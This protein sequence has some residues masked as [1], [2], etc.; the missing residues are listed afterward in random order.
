MAGA[1]EW[2]WP[3]DEAHGPDGNATGSQV[4]WT[5]ASLQAFMLMRA[6]ECL[7]HDPGASIIS[8]SQLDNSNYCQDEHE[9]AIIAE[10]MSINTTIT[11]LRM[12]DNHVADRVRAAAALALPRSRARA[13]A[14]GLTRALASHP[15]LARARMV[16]PHDDIR[17]RSSSPR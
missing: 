4:C 17:A 14:P 3:R 8:I 7:R 2:F 15:P 6:K 11:K 10:A 13:R 12:A 16:H 1:G 9:A 5:N